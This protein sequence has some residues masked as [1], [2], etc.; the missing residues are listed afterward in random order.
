M[1]SL[2]QA[3]PRAPPDIVTTI[4][5][6]LDVKSLA[7]WRL[8]NKHAFIDVEAKVRKLAYTLEKKQLL[9]GSFIQEPTGL[10]L[11][12]AWF[13]FM[14]NVFSCKQCYKYQ[15]RNKVAEAEQEH[16][17]LDC[18][19]QTLEIIHPLMIVLKH[20][21]VLPKNMALQLTMDCLSSF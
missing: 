12:S 16:L 5:S 19:R 2:Y 8:V 17:C 1:L 9:G 14:V 4:E 6:F 11:G 7:A 10:W 13:Q 18:F 20:K 15:L 21:R 3:L